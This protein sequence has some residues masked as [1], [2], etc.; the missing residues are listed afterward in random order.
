MGALA[1]ER[2]TSKRGHRPRPQMTCQNCATGTKSCYGARKVEDDASRRDAYTR[3]FFTLFLFPFSFFFLSRFLSPV[4]SRSLTFL[5]VPLVFRATPLR[6]D[7][8]QTNHEKK[9]EEE[10]AAVRPRGGGERRAERRARTAEKEKEEEE[11]EEGGR[12]RGGE[13]KGAHTHIYT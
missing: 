7:L 9:R 13:G 11:G 3:F 5:R 12:R 4:F 2:P 8:P 1:R 10:R 6:R